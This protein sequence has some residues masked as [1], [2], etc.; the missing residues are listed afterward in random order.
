MRDRSDIERFF[1]HCVYIPT[2]TIFLNDEVDQDLVDVAIKGLHI[3][4]SQS[5][6]PITVILNT[7]GGDE[8]HG[9]AIYDAIRSCRSLVTIKGMG[10]V[11]SMGSMIIQAADVRVMSPNS[12]F[13]F[14]YGDWGIDN[15]PKIAKQWMKEEEKFS[16]M[17]EDLYLAKIREVHPRFTRNKLQKMLDF[18]T[19]L[20]AQEALELGLIDKID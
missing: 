7:V 13:M 11:M 16:A 19:I 9:M 14:H 1:D 12:K 3:L 20:N 18:D 6:A 10:H 15:H 2:R 4:D 17:M 5:T 8:Y